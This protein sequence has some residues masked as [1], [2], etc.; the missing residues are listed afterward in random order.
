MHKRKM[1]AYLGHANQLADLVVVEV[2]ESLPR[3]R[4]LLDLL[5]DFLRD[6]AELSQWRHRL[7]PG[8][9][10]EKQMPVSVEISR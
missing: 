1:H 6:L 3:E 7:P 9:G 5:D 4:F 10:E 2:V 8:G